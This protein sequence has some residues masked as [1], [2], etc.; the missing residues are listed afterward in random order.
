MA[1]AK[2]PPTV[3]QN[4]SDL[5]AIKAQVASLQNEAATKIEEI[6]DGFVEMAVVFVDLVGSTEFK[7]VHA[8]E[9]E[10]WILRMMQFG[11]V[12]AAYAVQQGGRVIKYI[13]DEVM[14]GFDKPA[15][16]DKAVSFLGGL[17]GVVE[18][19]SATGD[20]GPYQDRRRRGR[21]LLAGFQ[22][23]QGA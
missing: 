14:I 2:R 8:L 18:Q 5:A 6:R 22:G 19:L 1:S 12:I 21:S 3:T 7:Q 17:P 13:G 15:H 20:E 23:P 10:R 16:L 4:A 11:E 9:P